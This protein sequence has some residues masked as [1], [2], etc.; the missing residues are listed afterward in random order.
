M[1]V[2][3]PWKVEDSEEV[4]FLANLVKSSSNITKSTLVAFLM[5][6]LTRKFL[7]EGL[8]VG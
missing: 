5:Q 4:R 1:F 2:A 6:S 8:I 7:S 3:M